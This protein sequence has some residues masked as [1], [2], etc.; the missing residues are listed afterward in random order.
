[1]LIDYYILVDPDKNN[2]CKLGITKN[3]KQR[4][5]SYRTANP[6]CYF[7]KV[8]KD[9]DKRH[10]RKI[11]DVLSD[12]FRVHREYVYANPLLVKNII[13]GYFLDQEEN[14]HDMAV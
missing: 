9:V 7:L 12:C 1:M 4:I 10:E 3:A 5:K 11:L 14:N 2:R 6:R 13:E 8:Y